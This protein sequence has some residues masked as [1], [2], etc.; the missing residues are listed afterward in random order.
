[1]AK[2][3]NRVPGACPDRR[4]GR[5]CI[6][7]TG[8]SVGLNRTSK[9]FC[10]AVLLAF[11]MLIRVGYGQGLPETPP[12][13]VPPEKVRQKWDSIRITVYSRV[14][15]DVN[16]RDWGIRFRLR[17]TTG[18]YKFET[19]DELLDT[20]SDHLQSLGFR[21]S[22]EFEFPTKF[23][24]VAFVPNVELSF[25]RLRDSGRNLLSGA[26]TGA[27]RYKKTRDNQD[28]I[29][30][31]SAKYGSRYDEEGLNLSDYIELSF[32]A[33]LRKSLSIRVGAERRLV[34]VPF[35]KY[36]YFADNLEF[37]TGQGLLF[38]VSERFELG[39]KFNTVPGW[40]LAGIRMPDIRISYFLGDGVK[41][42]KIRI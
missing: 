41:G 9:R 21:P 5:S 7:M 37:E 40:R 39:L 15:R 30:Q 42:I 31:A 6:D 2:S 18:I 4:G 13:E 11:G 8:T 36:S 12:D 22:L 33:D 38:D 26:L 32:A 16:E 25:N 14:L 10:F 3:V 17:A 28:L 29:L 1:M 34:M 23:R 20:D 27:F 35:G 19:L 24:N